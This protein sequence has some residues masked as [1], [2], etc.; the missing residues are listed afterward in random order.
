[1]AI[2]KYRQ[3]RERQKIESYQ[4]SA[5]ATPPSVI[6]ILNNPIHSEMLFTL[7]ENNDRDDLKKKLINR[8][9]LEEA[10]FETLN[11]YRKTIKEALDRS[12]EIMSLLKGDREIYL[13]GSLSEHFSKLIGNIGPDKV[14]DFLGNYLPLIYVENPEKFKELG[15]RIKSIQEIEKN[16]DDIN[17]KIESFARDHNIPQEVIDKFYELSATNRGEAMEFLKNSIRQNL[18]LVGKVR[19]WLGERGMVGG[20]Q[21]VKEYVGKIDQIETIEEEYKN[22]DSML[23]EVAETIGKSIFE[24][25]KGRELLSKVIY[26]QRIAKPNF[27]FREAGDLVK[28]YSEGGFEDD[29]RGFLEQ[30]QVENWDELGDEEREKLKN[31]FRAQNRERF[32]NR[33]GRVADYLFG[34]KGIFSRQ[35]DDFLNNV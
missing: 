16:I 17:S 27:S 32:R 14:R 7:L 10:D 2:E 4:K 34:R 12:N 20:R 5:E 35:L 15:D 30:E 13:C 25:S 29:W 19:N 8:E 26:E 23:K 21:F 6:E 18:S 33:I 24:S 31:K 1:M 3:E 11:E 9:T 22:I 28:R